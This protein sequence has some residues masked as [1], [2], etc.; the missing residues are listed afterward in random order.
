MAC[1]SSGSMEPPP[2]CSLLVPSKRLKCK[3]AAGRGEEGGGDKCGALGH[4]QWERG[5]GG[6]RSVVCTPVLPHHTETARS[7]EGEE[8]DVTLLTET[9]RRFT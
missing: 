3:G 7:R 8:T 6:S 2:H 9:Q 1:F 5:G 4:T